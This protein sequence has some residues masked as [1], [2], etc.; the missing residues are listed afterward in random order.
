MDITT[1]AASVSGL[2]LQAKLETVLRKAAALL[3]ADI[4]NRL[5]ALV[6]PT[7]LAIMAGVVLIWA[8]SHFVG[9]G[10]IADVILLAAGWL[11]IG[12]AAMQGGE[13]LLD[14]AVGTQA[15]KTTADL[16]KAAKDLADAITILG[17]DVVLGLL[18]KG[19]PKGT[20]K[21]VQG[22]MPSYSQFTRAMPKAGPMRIYEAKLVF[23]RS[24]FAGQGGTRPDNVATIGRDF[25]PGAKPFPEVIRSVRQTVYH[26]R[27][28]QRLTQAFSLLGRPGL[29]M[30]MGAYK[31]SYI[32][33]YIEEAAAEA[34]GLA[35]TGG[36]RPG[37]L[38]AI[39]FPL[40]GNYGITV[41]KMGEEAKGVLLGPI[42]VGGATYNAF[43]GAAH[44]DH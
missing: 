18:L 31:R 25:F 34:Y 10:E 8:G 12:A 27:I 20:F 28:H 14:F 41:A 26:E 5:L 6:T 23:S 11:M 30:K 32:L 4:G 42:T 24:K 7:S 19:K 36:A 33:R 15:A 16:D 17:V 2:S 38:S 44:N 1:S 22:T 35:R 37:E 43:Y 13:K 9:V 29:Y 40:N 3:P 39:Q 21:S